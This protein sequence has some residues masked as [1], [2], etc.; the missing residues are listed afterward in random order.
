MAGNLGLRL[1]QQAQPTG[2]HWKSKAEVALA[3]CPKGDTF[4]YCERGSV[5]AED[6]LKLTS[7]HWL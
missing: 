3:K 6:G 5:S 7:K 4:V 2:R 1:N